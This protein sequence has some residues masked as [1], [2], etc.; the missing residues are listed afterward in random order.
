LPLT[1]F[2][3]A[4]SRA[5]VDVSPDG[6]SRIIG[7]ILSGGIGLAEGG[8]ARVNALRFALEGRTARMNEGRC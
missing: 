5:A 7:P 3:K 4:G 1:V 8:R 6:S 2:G